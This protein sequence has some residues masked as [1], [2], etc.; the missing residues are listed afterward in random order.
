MVKRSRGQSSEAPSRRSWRVMVP[1]DSAFH[2][3]DPLEE[4]LAA[5]ALRG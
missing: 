4:R 1:P 5:D 2:C 3:P